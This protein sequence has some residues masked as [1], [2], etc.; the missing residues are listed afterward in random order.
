MLWMLQRVVFGKI[1]NP[2][3]AQLKDLNARE[4]GLLLPLL[5]LMFFM[6]VFP[7]P[8]LDRSKASIE[9]VRNRIV[10]QAGGVFASIRGERK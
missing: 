1:T 10:G 9:A 2:K 3:N 7:R 8:F 5:V 6:G 4:I